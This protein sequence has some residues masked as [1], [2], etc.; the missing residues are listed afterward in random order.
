MSELPKLG[1]LFFPTP[2]SED[3]P[4]IVDS[5]PLPVR[6]VNIDGIS[7][8]IFGDGTVERILTCD[9]QFKNINGLSPGKV[10]LEN[11]EDQYEFVSAGFNILF[12]DGWALTGN[13]KSKEKDDYCFIKRKYYDAN[14]WID[15]KE[16]FKR[17]QA[18]TE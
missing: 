9:P 5:F 17:R 7:Y 18:Q 8:E 13:I 16:L 6:H 4:E 15:G 10:D 14:G 12:S 1:S 2:L 3:Y 11:L